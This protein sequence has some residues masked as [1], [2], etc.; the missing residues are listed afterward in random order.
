MATN[1]QRKKEDVFAI[2]P[3]SAG[4]VVP[5]S[6]IPP[7]RRAP[8][9]TP[10]MFG[11]KVLGIPLT[12]K[13]QRIVNAL[14]PTRSASSVVCCNEAGKT[15]K[16][17]CTLILWHVCVFPRRGENGGVITT[18]GSWAQ[19]KNQLVPALK[20]YQSKFPRWD[21]QDV[22]IKRDGIPNWMAFSVTNPGRAEGFHGSPTDPLM[23]IVDE[24]K[25][26]KDDIF[27][28]IEDRCRPQR[29]GYF[30][31]PGFSMGRFHESHTTAAASYDRHKVT[32]DDCPWVDRLEMKRLIAKAGG[33]DYE[34]GLADPWIRSAYFAEFM[35]FVEDSLVALSDIEEALADPPSPRPGQRHG[36]CDFAAGGDENVFALAVGN[37]VMLRDAWRDR[38]TMAA[39]GRFVMNFERAR[40]EFGLRPEEIE[41]DADGLGRPVVD[42]IREVGWPI[43][44]FHAESRA[45]EPDK[46]VNR[47][48]EI[49]CNGCEAI[50]GRKWLLPDDPD[51]KGQ[52]VDRQ[53]KPHS[54]GKRRVESKQ[55]LFRRQARDGRPSRSP[56]RADALL[57]AMAPLPMIGAMSLVGS[58]PERSP[59]DSSPWAGKPLDAD[60]SEMSVPEEVL[61][62][63][64]AGG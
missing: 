57:G 34:R 33:G 45:F 59:Y 56:D 60:T 39:A 27:R 61:R 43:L 17:I 50:K 62:G 30:S 44:D 36:W 11:V 13:Q 25:S 2:V 8:Y 1:K 47:A 18:S 46:F 49:W 21:F 63:F 38:N 3:P 5:F 29:T 6:Q 42:R 52:L 22:E 55:D 41:G 35:P 16:M 31:S 64:D 12:E 19:I 58:E 24:A 20:G 23:A 28:T 10:A 48:S 7:E 14:A 9:A 26:V 37:R 53:V 51:L 15:T 54:S 32:V 4:P 40:Q